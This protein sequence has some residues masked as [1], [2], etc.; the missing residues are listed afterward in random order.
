[1][2]V[3]RWV[4]RCSTD[5]RM[6]RPKHYQHVKNKQQQ[7]CAIA[8][9]V[10][11]HNAILQLSCPLAN[12]ASCRHSQS[13]QQASLTRPGSKNK[14]PAVDW[15]LAEIPASELDSLTS[16]LCWMRCPCCP[17]LLLCFG[18]YEMKHPQGQLAGS[19]VINWCACQ[20]RHHSS[21]RAEAT[22]KPSC[23]CCE[24][25]SAVTCAKSALF[26]AVN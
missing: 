8:E 22:R 18:C 11:K 13:M 26:N 12:D 14:L 23:Q 6:F 17:I 20:K 10:L 19:D 9:L 16:C 5:A 7:Y 4:P 1:M 24:P 3:A 15:L 2:V 25:K 21:N